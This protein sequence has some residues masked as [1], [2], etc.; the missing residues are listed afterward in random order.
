MSKN[1]ELKEEN[2]VNNISKKIEL[3]FE[4]EKTP[5]FQRNKNI[6]SLIIKKIEEEEKYKNH[7]KTEIDEYFNSPD[8]YFD[9]NS[10]IAINKTI[11]L[12]D[13]NVFKKQQ[14]HRLNNKKSNK[15]I[16]SNFPNMTPIKKKSFIP[17]ILGTSSG[18]I[19]S[20][21]IP[22]HSQ[23]YEI[24]DNEKLK[25]IF[26][27]YKNI[28]S[29][30]SFIKEYN[31]D[32]DSKNIPL[33]ISKSLSVQKKR[34]K[35]NRNDLNNLREMSGVLSKRLNKKKNDLLINSIDSYRYKGN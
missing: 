34:L 16:I 2:K 22:E 10:P 14:T 21:N 13:I 26:E 8:K 28:N 35:T 6:R 20:N 33:D 7:I 24:I 27:S 4:E 17:S 30:K 31:L 3:N 9:K 15:A 19:N 11:N 12:K 25:N 18:N 5:S 32:S 23:R 1:E 29:K